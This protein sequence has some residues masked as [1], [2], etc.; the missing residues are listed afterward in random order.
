[1]KRKQVHKTREKDN[2]YDLN[3]HQR[4]L[5]VIRSRAEILD[6]LR[7]FVFNCGCQHARGSWFLLHGALSLHPP[8]LAP[9]GNKCAICTGKWSNIF[10]RVKKDRVIRFL[11]SDHFEKWVPL[12]AKNDNIVDVLWTGERW[13]IEDMMVKKTVPKSSVDGLFLQLI[14]DQILVLKKEQSGLVWSLGRTVDAMNPRES[15]LNYKFDCNWNG[16]NIF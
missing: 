8:V 16:I 2:K 12:P 6:V 14:A 13:R 9:C 11:Q 1:M 4:K 10:M 15:I 5:L 3:P 7:F